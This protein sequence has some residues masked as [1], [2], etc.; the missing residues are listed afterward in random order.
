MAQVQSNFCSLLHELPV[1]DLSILVTDFINITLRTQDSVLF[2]TAQNR[3]NESCI[4]K[5]KMKLNVE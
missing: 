2:Q 3:P 5:S 4:Y 1:S